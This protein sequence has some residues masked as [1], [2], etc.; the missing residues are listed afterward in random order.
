MGAWGNKSF[1]NDTA[2]D[3]ILG[4]EDG[5]DSQV[6]AA[7][8]AAGPAGKARVDTDTACKALAAAELVAA[9]LGRGDD[10][11]D[12]DAAAWLAK[13]RDAVRQLGA[14]RAHSA[15]QRVYEGSELRALFDE[16]AAKSGKEWHEDVAEL[17]RRLSS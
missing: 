16:P 8:D 13:H 1:E 12:D 10:R 11:L 17:L 2:A 7:L 3:W 6:R 14:A 5:D 4:L 15:V 9:A